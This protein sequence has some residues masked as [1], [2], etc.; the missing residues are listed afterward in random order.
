MANRI[1]QETIEAINEA[2][3]ICKCKAQ[4]AREL[5]VSLYAVNKYLDPNW[6]PKNDAASASQIKIDIPDFDVTPFLIENI[7]SLCMLSEEE[8]KDLIE[9][10][11]EVK[12]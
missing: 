9:L 12:I 3:A 6:Q 8:K 7:A 10:Q 5:G 4:V 11:K 1:S 2:Y